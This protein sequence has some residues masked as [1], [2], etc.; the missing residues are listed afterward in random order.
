[1]MLGKVVPKTMMVSRAGW[2]VDGSGVL[3]RRTWYE[4]LKYQLNRIIPRGGF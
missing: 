2:V 3:R 1:M 4:R